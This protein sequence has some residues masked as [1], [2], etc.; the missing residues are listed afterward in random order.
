MITPHPVWITYIGWPELRDIVIANQERYATEEFQF[1][2][3]ISI[4]VNWPYRSEDVLVFENGDV[5][6]CEAFAR[7]VRRLEN[8]SLDKPFQKRYPELRGFCKFTEDRF[9]VQQS[10]TLQ[11]PT[12]DRIY[13]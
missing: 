3:T 1:L 9:L 5:R 7:H 2:Y 12:M 8:W 6:A 13:R 4:N 11:H 10:T